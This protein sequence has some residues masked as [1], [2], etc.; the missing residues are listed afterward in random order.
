MQLRHRI[1]REVSLINIVSSFRSALLH[2]GWNICDKIPV[3]SCVP[4]WLPVTTA[5]RQ[6]GA[7]R[8]RRNRLHIY[9]LDQLL[10]HTAEAL[11]DTGRQIND[12]EW[13]FA[14]SLCG[15]KLTACEGTCNGIVA[16]RM[17]RGVCEKKK[18]EKQTVQNFTLRSLSRY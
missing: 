15:E 7:L 18:K 8:K 13:P 12:C 17:A 6:E 14:I 1:P 16:Q 9:D 4:C 10:T 2:R 11:Q 3:P 5:I